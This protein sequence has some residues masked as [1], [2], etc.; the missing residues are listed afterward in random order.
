STRSGEEV[1]TPLSNHGG[2]PSATTLRSEA[3]GVP[4]WRCTSPRSPVT[5][6]SAAFHPSNE[7]D[8]APAATAARGTGIPRGVRTTTVVIGGCDPLCVERGFRSISPSLER[9]A[10][11]ATEG[12]DRSETVS[13][14]APPTDLGA[15]EEPRIHS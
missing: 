6:R 9:D 13:G 8:G 11:P 5:A 7:S 15:R 3:T 1:N 4:T 14:D 10:V 12:D 2:Q